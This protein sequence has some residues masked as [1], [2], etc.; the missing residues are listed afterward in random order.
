MPRRKPPLSEDDIA[1]FR[2][3]VG[4]VRPVRHNQHEHPPSRRRVV[5]RHTVR[6]EPQAM[7][8]S[9]KFSPSEL[10]SSSEEE[11]KFVRDGLSPRQMSKLRRG[12][13]SIEAELDLH[14]LTIDAA[15][16]AL[17]AFFTHCLHN[18]LRCLRI[19]HGKGT[20]SP[21]GRPVIKPLVNQWLRHRPD[22]LAFVSAPANDGGTGA[23]YV[24]RKIN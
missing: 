20:R 16:R 3:E 14:G 11:L 2:N 13:Y 6:D 7:F 4:T 18:K 15:E 21:S 9:L 12:R 23:I 19:I 8:E 24:L 10:A 17:Q 1:L 22:V 5:A